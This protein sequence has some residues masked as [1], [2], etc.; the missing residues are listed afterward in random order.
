MDTLNFLT[1]CSSKKN[2]TPL[3]K[4]LKFPWGWVMEVCKTQTMKEMYK[5]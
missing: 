2:S 3:Q 1:K 4:G 5:P